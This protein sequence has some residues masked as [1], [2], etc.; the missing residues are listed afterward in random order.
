ML[1]STDTFCGGLFYRGLRSSFR[2]LLVGGTNFEPYTD[3]IRG[4]N[5]GT[6]VLLKLPF[7]I[8]ETSSIFVEG[9]YK[10]L[11]LP[12]DLLLLF[13]GKTLVKSKTFLENVSF[14]WHEGKNGIQNAII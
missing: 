5:Y 6:D 11:T 14:I 13:V 7:A 4:T 2:Y 1:Y 3:H 9:A 10:D 8:F 12:L